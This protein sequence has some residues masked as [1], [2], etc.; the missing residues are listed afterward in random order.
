M[1]NL[2]GEGDEKSGSQ[3]VDVL[4]FWKCYKNMIWVPVTQQAV[5]VCPSDVVS[6]HERNVLEGLLFYNRKMAIKAQ[7]LSI[8]CC[9]AAK[10]SFVETRTHLYVRNLEG[11][12]TRP[13]GCRWEGHGRRVAKGV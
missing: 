12:G 11:R 6:R 1:G 9:Q 5:S 3:W 7:A 2:F 10:P 4:A 8:P 13:L